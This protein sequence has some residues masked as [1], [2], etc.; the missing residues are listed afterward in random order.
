MAIDEDVRSLTV[1]VDEGNAGGMSAQNTRDNDV[2]AT[3][4]TVATAGRTRAIDGLEDTPLWKHPMGS[5]TPVP[6]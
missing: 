4:V 1:A 2:D 6:A 3:G 5:G